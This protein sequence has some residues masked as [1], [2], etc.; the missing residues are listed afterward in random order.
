MKLDLGEPVG[1]W[2]SVWAW[3]SLDDSLRSQIT[4]HG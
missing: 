2:A 3:D 4:N 1:I